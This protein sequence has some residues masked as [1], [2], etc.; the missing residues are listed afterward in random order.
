MAD[1]CTW[2]GFNTKK[3]KSSYA[4]RRSLLGDT[5]AWHRE[6]LSNVCNIADVNERGI[7]CSKCIRKL[8]RLKVTNA[9]NC[10]A[11]EMDST[12]SDA[13]SSTKSVPLRASSVATTHARCIVCKRTVLGGIC[14]KIPTEARFDLLIRFRVY[15][16]SECRIC[17]QHLAGNRLAE[18]VEWNTSGDDEEISLSCDQASKI[19][20]QFLMLSREKERYF[21]LDFN[22]PYFTDNDCLVWTGWTRQQF[23]SMLDCLHT[24]HDSPNRD[25]STALLIF[26]V[27][28]KTGLSFQQIASLLNQNNENGRKMV[29]NAFSSVTSDL[30]KFFVPLHLGCSHIAREKA[31]SEHMTAYSS[32]LYGGKLCIIW[33]GTYYYI[34]KSGNYKFGRQTYSGQKHR[35]LLKFMSIVLPD[36]YVLESIGPYF[37]DGKNNDA[38]ITQHILSLHGDLVEWLQ[39]GDVCVVDRGFRDVLDVFEDLG[40]E[41]KMPSFLK[42]GMAQHN[43]EEAN[44]SRL[45]TK[46]R[47]AV[48][49][50][51][52]RMKKWL[53]F[54]KVIHHDFL[55]V[56]GPLN[57]IL[58]GAMNAF[59]PPLICTN[60]AD[61]EMARNM[62]RKAEETRNNLFNRIEKGPLSSRGRWTVLDS[63]EAVP[64]F[65]K[66]SLSDLQELTFGTYQLKQAKS[67]AKEHKS[68]EGD[69]TIDVHS[70]APGL[71]RV[72][73]QSRHINAKRYFC[74]IEY[75][76]NQIA[77]WFCHCKAGQRTVGC[78][79]HVS[80]V[81]WYLGH[82]RHQMEGQLPIKKGPNVMNAADH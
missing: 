81:L 11:A 38:G 39:E 53:F 75:S 30:D 21:A 27:K 12:S 13:E 67:Y 41:T 32:V 22:N 59:R 79:A 23:Q 15:S 49:A 42:P 74:W 26:W 31:L 58:T 56:V 63:N 36:G 66:L 76:D 40:L 20:E 17:F 60:D 7:L 9:Q 24:T 43:T 54:D 77:A 48:E 45:V 69:Y 5:Y 70:K 62:L 3:R 55:D 46:V 64:D 10:G 16:D 1:K 33:D 68:E 37:A 61:A 65:P 4:N 57:R 19:I 73:I 18:S 47:W 78:C 29:S 28:L 2:C 25:K 82:A 71:L 6:Y 44:Q 80:S 50:Y 14:T 72:R 52:G 34:Q 8:N 35:P 51:H